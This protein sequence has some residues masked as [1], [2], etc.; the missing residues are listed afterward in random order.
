MGD[1]K[2]KEG[3][4]RKEIDGTIETQTSFPRHVSK[5]TFLASQDDRNP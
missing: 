3:K 4:G 1:G 5:P 2:G